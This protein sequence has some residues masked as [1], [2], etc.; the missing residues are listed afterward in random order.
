DLTLYAREQRDG[1]LLDLV[2][3]ADL[4]AAARMAELLEQLQHVLEQMVTRPEE[5]ISQLSLV[6]PSAAVR[7]PD[8]ARPLAVSWGGTVHERFARLAHRNP[9]RPALMDAASVW[10]YA[11]LDAWG[12]RLANALIARGVRSQDVVAI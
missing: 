12:N 9:D 8:P 6:T 7:L 5:R 10:T 3:N 2:Y 11:E 1:I 4:F